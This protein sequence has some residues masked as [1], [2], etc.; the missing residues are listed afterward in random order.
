MKTKFNLAELNG[1]FDFKPLSLYANKQLSDDGAETDG[2]P[3]FSSVAYTGARMRPNGY[4]IDTIVDLEG[5][6]S[7]NDDGSISIL[8]NHDRDQ[9]VG[10]GKLRID[11]GKIMIDGI[12]TGENKYSKEVVSHAGNGFQ[13]Q[14][15]IGGAVLKTEHLKTKKEKAEING[16]TVVG[17]LLLIREIEVDETSF[18]S[19]GADK[20][21]SAAIA[22]SFNPK[23][24]KMEMSFEEWLIDIGVDA[25]TQTDEE[26]AA[27]RE[28]YDAL[29][30]EAAEGSEGAAE[31]GDDTEEAVAAALKREREILAARKAELRTLCA[32]H[33]RAD[34]ANKAIA[35]DWNKEETLSELLKDV[36]ASRSSYRAPLNNGAPTVD[37][38]KVLEV[39]MLRSAGYEIKEGEYSPRVMEAADNSD[40]SGLGLHGLMYYAA[41]SAGSPIGA[42]G[43][44]DEKLRAA[45]NT[46]RLQASGG[47]TTISVSGILSNIA[48]KFLLAGY[49][50]NPS[51][52]DKVAARASSPDFKTMESYRLIDNGHLTKVAPGGEIEHG[53]LTEQQ[54]TNKVD[55]YGKIIAID[56]QHLINDDLGAF[57]N[58]ARLLGVSAF[59]SREK[60]VFDAITNA[61]AFYS[62]ANNNIIDVGATPPYGQVNPL[63]F[64]G[65]AL[66]EQRLLEQTDGSDENN[67]IMV[68]GAY[69]VVSPQN[70]AEAW[71]LYQSSN[72][73][74]TTNA[75]EPAGATNIFAGRYLPVVSPFL[76][77]ADWYLNA[78]PNSVAS[79]QI[80]YL[81][82][83]A[84]PTIESSDLDFDQLGVQTRVVFD[85]GVGLQDPRGSVKSVGA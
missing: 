81:N 29:V 56:R 15:S 19:G 83:K 22:A 26:L 49:E 30:E 82:G 44:S 57:A 24:L 23:E 38:N 4:P 27:L 67:P 42:M 39:A 14:Q 58:M 68:V 40:Y 60:I 66:A 50:A 7:R 55:T 16:E 61:G 10:Q 65:L 31:S 72:L 36:R 43:M 46:Q 54:Y 6:R 53:K 75:G 59:N 9:L 17:P 41:K 80:A 73:V 37:D 47:L 70:S 13:W 71:R 74:E 21:T 5:V 48:N 20:Y 64:N 2:P 45:F 18:V 35:N 79:L 25:E 34:F 69:L 32:S 8:L 76:T 52:V 84:T 63:D 33:G 11:D 1:L 85:F 12:I 78:N 62:N 3:S 51:S 28:R 77:G